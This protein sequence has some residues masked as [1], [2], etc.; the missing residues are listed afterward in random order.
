MVR[1]KPNALLNDDSISASFQFHNGSIKTGI[2]EDEF[3]RIGK[4]QFHNGS[5][6][7]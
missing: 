7:T 3:K 6:K 1:L 4:F 2:E 5:I